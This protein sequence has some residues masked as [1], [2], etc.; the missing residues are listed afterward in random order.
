[1]YNKIDEKQLDF[2]GCFFFIA[3]IGKNSAD[4]YAPNEDENA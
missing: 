1:L 2:F 4:G 3:Q